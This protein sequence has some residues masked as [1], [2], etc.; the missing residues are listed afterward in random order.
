MKHRKQFTLKFT[1]FLIIVL[2]LLFLNACSKDEVITL[3]KHNAHQYTLDNG[4][5]VIIN[6]DHRHPVVAI[7]ALVNIGSANEGKYEGGGISH[8]IEHML[9]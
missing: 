8:F 6:E 5:R 3:Q 2:S 1:Y 7:Y 4:L 9:F